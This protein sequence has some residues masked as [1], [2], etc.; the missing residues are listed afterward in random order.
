[1]RLCW[2]RLFLFHNLTLPNEPTANYLLDGFVE[3]PALGLELLPTLP[4]HLPGS[5]T[6]P[7]P[8]RLLKYWFQLQKSSQ[9]MVLFPLP[10]SKKALV[11]CSTRSEF[12][13]IR[14]LRGISAAC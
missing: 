13:A 12:F 3:W 11:T 4:D 6:D 10:T 5:G 2:F 14:V 7:F 9:A 1:M 8:S